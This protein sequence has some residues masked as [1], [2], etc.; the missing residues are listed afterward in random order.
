M[1][2]WDEPHRGWH[3]RGHLGTLLQNIEEATGLSESD[4]EVLRYAALFH[5]VI[6][7]P[8][9][10]TN[11]EDS[12]QLAATALMNYDRREEV[13]RIILATKSHQSKEELAQRF[14]AWDCAIL[15][16]TSWEKL[17]QYEQGIAFEYR[18][19]PPDIY[20]RERSRFLRSAAMEY[21]NPLLDR[22][23]DEVNLV[24]S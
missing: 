9:S 6:Y 10:A 13:F 14:N 23:A 12:A 1:S 8:L 21:G 15:H 7:D 2:R 24:Q 19:V 5:D 3:G 16:D 11:E 18:V 17:Q 22:L 20:R 4:C